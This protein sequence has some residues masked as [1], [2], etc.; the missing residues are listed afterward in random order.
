MKRERG[1]KIEERTNAVRESRAYCHFLGAFYAPGLF[2]FVHFNP[3]SISFFP[4]LSLLR[5]LFVLH[6][7][8][9]RCSF[10]CSFMFSQKVEEL[11]FLS[12]KS[13]DIW[14][15]QRIEEKKKQSR[16]PPLF[17]DISSLTR[18]FIPF[19]LK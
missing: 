15:E 19:Y 12:I 6:H 4:C 18:H 1:R 7:F 5:F 11:V 3:F 17:L 14:R 10:F 16:D 9:F 2:S 8:S 13:G